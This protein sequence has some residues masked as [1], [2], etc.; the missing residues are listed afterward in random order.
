MSAPNESPVE[1]PWTSLRP[2][3]LRGLVEEFVTRDGTDY[4]VRERSLEERVRDVMRQLERDEVAIVWDPGS[5]TA[6]LVPRRRAQR[7]S[8]A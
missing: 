1:V 3:A 4:G 8:P 2:E 6:N 5:G 7:G